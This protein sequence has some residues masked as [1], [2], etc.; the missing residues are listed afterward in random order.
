MPQLPGLI[1]VNKWFQTKNKPTAL[2]THIHSHTHTQKKYFSLMLVPSYSF[3]KT[4]SIRISINAFYTIFVAILITFAIISFLY[5]QSRFFS[6][7]VQAFSASLEQAQ[8]AYTNLHQV[9]EREQNHLIEG[10][11]SLQSDITEEQLSN[12]EEQLLQHQDYLDNLETFWIHVKGLEKRLQRYENYRQEIIEQLS[13]SAHIPVVSNILNDIQQS[14][15]SLMSA[16]EEYTNFSSSFRGE[17]AEQNQIM[18][19]LAYSPDATQIVSAEDAAQNLFYH[20]TLLTH[21]LEEQQAL[22]SQLNQQ[23]G[24]AAPHIRRDRY[25]PRLLDWSYVR[26]I[27]PRNTPVTVTDV[28]TGLTYRVNSFSHGNHADVFPVG[29][30]D[31]ATLLRTFNGQWSW[32]TRPIW[33]HINGRKVAASINGMPHGGG[34]GNGNNMNGH[35]CIHFRGSRTHSGS[36]FHERDHQNSVME[37]YR[38]NF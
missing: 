38:A 28:R 8:M 32:D 10:V 35:I 30:E 23:V 16:L 6:Q 24:T 34:G 9:T 33:V 13:Q 20:M 21:V 37:A 3:G 18:S 5:I 29:P 7:E 25:G 4:R 15:L 22:F 36:R 31:T 17:I 14:Q 19:L 2:H 11:V 1:K 12:Q 26:N 27:L